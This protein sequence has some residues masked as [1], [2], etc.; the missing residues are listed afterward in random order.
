MITDIFVVEQVA[1][2]VAGPCLLK[3]VRPAIEYGMMVVN[4]ANAYRTKSK[5]SENRRLVFLHVREV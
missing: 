4:F 3:T 2:Q 5:F 1:G